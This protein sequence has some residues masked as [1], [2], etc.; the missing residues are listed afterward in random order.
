MSRLKGRNG[1]FAVDARGTVSAVALSPGAAEDKGIEQ[2]LNHLF[3]RLAV[4]VPEEEVGEGAKWTVKSVLDRGPIRIDEVVTVELRK[5]EGSRMDLSLKIERTAPEHILRDAPGIP[6]G[7]SFTMLGL[8]GKGAGAGQ[9]DLTSLVPV[10]SKIEN[11]QK[12][13]MLF[14][15]TTDGAERPTEVRDGFVVTMTRK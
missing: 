4:P 6:P 15:S 11:T 12:K 9:W 1:A 13:K 2:L 8:E 3:H 14:G 10:S 7:G 5:L